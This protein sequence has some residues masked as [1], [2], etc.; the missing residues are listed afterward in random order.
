MIRIALAAVGVLLLGIIIGHS[1][2]SPV[3]TEESTRTAP[4]DSSNLQNESYQEVLGQKETEIQALYDDNKEL[5]DKLASVSLEFA[6]MRKLMDETQMASIQEIETEEVVEPE[7][8]RDWGR[9]REW[10]EEE[11]AEREERRAEF[12]NRMRD[13]M[14]NRWDKVWENS[15]PESQARISEIAEKEQELMDLRL[16][17]REAETDEERDELRQAYEATRESVRDTM[18]TEQNAQLTAMAEKYGISKPEDI[19][20]FIRDSRDQMKNPVFQSGGGGDWRGG[21]GGGD[22]RGG[23]GRGGGGDRGGFQ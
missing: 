23:G 8:S 10:T 13:D 14:L 9:G 22:R 12:V 18:K 3:L 17:M 20:Q 2:N 19:E 15:S 4:V 7:D 6:S 11:R 5:E 21:G 16:A 1:I